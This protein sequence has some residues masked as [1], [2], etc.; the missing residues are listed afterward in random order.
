MK[1]EGAIISRGMFEENLA[2]KINHAQFRE[3]MV[4]LLPTKVNFDI[5][6]AYS[7]ILAKIIYLLPAASFRSEI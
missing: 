3:D 6:I 1:I 7:D 2:L 4:G 5:D